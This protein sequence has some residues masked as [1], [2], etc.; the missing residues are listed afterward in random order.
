MSISFKICKVQSM[1]KV[2]QP[3]WQDGGLKKQK[4]KT[5]VQTPPSTQENTLSDSLLSQQLENTGMNCLWGIILKTTGKGNIQ[6]LII[7]TL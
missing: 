4:Q 7:I 2:S 1:A 6:S 3:K 5:S